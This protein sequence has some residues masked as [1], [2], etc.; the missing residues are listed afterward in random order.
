M[1]LAV[2]LDCRGHSPWWAF[3]V[4]VAA[5]LILIGRPKEQPKGQDGGVNTYGGSGVP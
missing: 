2:A 5:M 3:F 4:P 1:A